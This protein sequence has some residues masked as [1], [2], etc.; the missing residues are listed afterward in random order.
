M[1]NTVFTIASYT[2]GPLLGLFSF[3]LFTKYPVK[4]KFVPVVAILSPIMVYLINNISIQW[5]GFYFGYTILL[6]NGMITFIGLWMIRKKD[7][8][9][10][11]V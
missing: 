11:Q 9:T 2:Y 3:G 5:F 10:C 1:I 6:L 7:L 8:P 4:D